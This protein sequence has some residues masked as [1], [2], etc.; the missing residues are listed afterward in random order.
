MDVGATL[1]A[2][3]SSGLG[4]ATCDVVRAELGS[5]LGETQRLKRLFKRAEAEAHFEAGKD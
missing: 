1:G 5:V 2:K 3:L 4:T